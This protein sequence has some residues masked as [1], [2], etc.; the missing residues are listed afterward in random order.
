MG[1]A[2][3]TGANRGIGLEL[4]RQLAAK[5][6]GVLAVCRRASDALQSAGAE[7][8]EGIDVT[9]PACLERLRAAIAAPIDLLI[10]N[11]GLLTKETRG[12]QLGRH[13][14]PIRDQLAGAARSD[15]HPA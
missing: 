3:V 10:N 2:V 12:A 13:S 6:W 5:G 9:D 8:I 15:A 4:A 14:T 11:A 7:V 1:Y